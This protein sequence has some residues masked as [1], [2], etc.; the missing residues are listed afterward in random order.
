RIPSF[1]IDFAARDRG[2]SDVRSVVQDVEA[3]LARLQAEGIAGVVLDLRGNHGGA[4]SEA[5]EMTAFFMA[6]APVA[7][8][9][10]AAK[11]PVHE[12]VP[13][14]R[15][16][17]YQGPVAILLD[18]ESASATELFAAALR[19]RG[20]A[21]VLGQRSFGQGSVQTLLELPFVRDAETRGS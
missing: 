5:V 13:N 6:P 20:R 19:D 11:E 1:Y 12:L 18:G 21:V 16:Q 4:L 2:D 17:V 14:E 7:L 3:V 9:E 10:Q 8:I 15:E